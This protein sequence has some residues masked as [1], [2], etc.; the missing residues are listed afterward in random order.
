MAKLHTG[1]A[2]IDR[3]LQVVRADQQFYEYI[4]F[5]NAA[6]L[7][8]SIHPE[9]LEYFKEAVTNL[10]VGESAS[11][12]IRMR[13][14]S[15][16]YHHV[17]ARV[18]GISIEG[19]A[20]SYVELIIQDIDDM[21][22]RLG[23][24]CDQNSIYREFID[25]WGE[26]LFIYAAKED[27]LHIFYGGT[28]N[29]VSLFRGTL[30]EFRNEIIQ[31]NL[32]DGTQLSDFESLCDRIAEGTKNFE[33]QLAIRDKTSDSPLKHC[34]ITCRTIQ[35]SQK[36]SLV[37][38]CIHRRNPNE[39]GEGADVQESFELDV[40][41][42]LLTK[43][44]ILEYTENLLQ[45]HPKYNVNLCVVDIDNFK[46]VNDTLGH[47][48]GDEVLARVA[49]ILK[50]AVAGKGHVGRI[51]GDE[52]F[53]VLEGVNTLSDL[54]GIL[55]GIRSNVEWAYKDRKEVPPVTC[56]IG[57]STYPDDALVYEDLFKIADKMLYRAKQKGKNRYIV[58]AA[59]VH[60]DVLSEGN[61]VN[62]QSAASRRQDREDLVLEVLECLARQINRPYDVLL[63]DI[64]TAFGLDEIHMFYGDAKKVL[65]ESYWNAQGETGRG[66][67]FAD[68]VHEENF[69][70]LYKE[71]N[72]AVIDN[73]GL[74]EQLCPRTHK[75]LM[76]HGIKVALIYKMDCKK[77]EGYITYCKMSDISRKWSDSDMAN[78][79]YISK[80][81]ELLI[82]D[83]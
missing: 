68:Y 26:Y 6:S 41:T 47:M 43:K 76:A 57:V 77:H 74:I 44:A 21:E 61:Q 71:H 35:N 22:E 60:G 18:V 31:R 2:T 51:G 39:S 5:E 30:A 37:L 25:M 7:A 29:G 15:E 67:S 10:E 13:T 55:R 17:L 75:Y 36:E 14:N 20:D 42:G 56:S 45:H 38:G 73:P 50:E 33:S 59:D 1:T 11:L 80:A 78:L 32:V 63:R 62:V 12:V 48:F 4:G 70:H 49:D 65:L 52:M 53:I 19:K 27:S 72:M 69:I 58:Y 82:N 54:R 46:Q 81:I 64:G 3:R 8:G 66:E 9:G 34:V 83:K 40:T 23:N 16:E 24:M 79:A 28:V